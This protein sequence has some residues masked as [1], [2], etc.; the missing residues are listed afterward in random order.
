MKEKLRSPTLVISCF[1]LCEIFYPTKIEF[2]SV[3]LKLKLPS[4]VLW[5]P[6]YN[7]L[8]YIISFS[9]NT[10]DGPMITLNIIQF[11]SRS[12]PNSSK[13]MEYGLR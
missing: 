4:C 8:Q 7:D 10:N 11:M 9:N 12:D 3:F 1:T 13:A 5:K 2:Y 6:Q